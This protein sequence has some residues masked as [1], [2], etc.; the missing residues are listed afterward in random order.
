LSFT[1]VIAAEE[2]SA[3]QIKIGMSINPGSVLLEGLRRQ[4]E[5]GTFTEVM[6]DS[7]DALIR[8]PSVPEP[9]Q[10][11][12]D[13]ALLLEDWVD[14]TV[15]NKL[16]NHPTLPPFRARVAVGTLCRTGLLRPANLNELVVE[17]DAA[18][19]HGDHKTAYG[20]YRRT[21]AFG[22]GTSRIH[23]HLAELAERFGDHAEAAEAY[24]AAVQQMSDP[25]ATVV[26]L[27][28][29]LR[30]GADKE[31]VLTQMVAIHL[32]LGNREETVK[33][34]LGLAELHAERGAREQ[35]MEAVREA[36]E[37]GAD[38]G[39]T[40]LMLARFCR[41]DGDVDQAALQLELAARAFHENERLDEA[42]QAWRELLAL[43]PG[44]CEYAKECAELLVWSG[45]KDDAVTVLRTALLTQKEA[46]EDV[47]LHV[48]E[49]LA[50]L[51]PNDVE[52]HDWLAQSYERRRDRDGA[53]KQ[54]KLAA[55]A[56][57]RTGDFAELAATLERIIELGGEK[58]DTYGWLA[59]TRVKLKQEGLAG[60]AFCKA[61]DA[62]LELGLLKDARPLIESAL[63]DL[64]ANLALRQRLA[65]VTNREGDRATA[66][67]QFLLAADLARGCGDRPTC[68]DM[69][70]QACRLRPDD[71]AARVRLAE[72]A[73]ELKDPNL[74]SILADVVRVAARTTNHGIALEH[75]RRRIANAGGL[76]YGPRCELVELLR[77]CGDTAGQLANGK[78][79]LNELLEQ[80]EFEK[81]VEILSRLVASHPK[82]SE[83][84]LQLAEVYAA[85]GDE[86]KAFRFYK[87]VVPLLQLD[88]K[89]S[90]AKVALD[91]L[92]GM[93]EE[94]EQ[95]MIIM[96]RERI[97]KGH[98]VD[99]D[100][101]RQEAE[102]DQRRRAAGLVLPLGDK[103][104]EK[105]PV[106]SE[107][108]LQRV[109]PRVITPTDDL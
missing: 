63:T 108:P 106:K 76:A 47:L 69:L 18:Y 45:K 86:R 13:A 92:Q 71:L 19:A 87:H 37:L 74:D 72:V 39:S 62:L 5:L 80:G 78:Q 10:L 101:I 56:Q 23:L 50:Q 46:S 54:L 22:Q 57:E 109:I 25:S 28:N 32:Q 9:A 11:S 75:A 16:L 36:Q 20:L 84:M 26:A 44:R 81:A 34:L 49:L 2:W 73:E 30:L 82:N 91:L 83:L 67:K 95:S 85:L 102:Q 93:S 42:I 60:E 88:G 43:L 100:K 14:G 70:V 52:C 53:T 64:P 55:S 90:E 6:P 29:A 21:L 15:A 94:H 66:M 4:D 65:Q 35:A 89:L 7:W 61:V 33:N 103:P 17:A 8:D 99:W 104:A 31:A 40:A 105:I 1:D 41:A 79:L 27:R 96:A 107:R 77:L 58:I 51:A 97:D 3:V 38:Q 59:R 48:Y 98:S 24:M 12:K 68:R